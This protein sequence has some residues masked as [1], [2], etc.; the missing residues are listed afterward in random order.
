MPKSIVHAVNGL[1]DHRAIAEAFV[2]YFADVCKPNS[3]Q[4]NDILV[5][6]FQARFSQYEGFVWDSQ[7]DHCKSAKIIQSIHKGKA[8]RV[9]GI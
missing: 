2:D 1:S 7:V 6:N 4:Q 3:N 8:P 5:D 9:D